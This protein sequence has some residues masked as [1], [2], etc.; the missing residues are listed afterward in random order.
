MKRSVVVYTLLH[1]S[2]IVFCALINVVAV[3]SGSRCCVK[4]VV[5]GMHLA[6]GKIAPKFGKWCRDG[7]VCKIKICFHTQLSLHL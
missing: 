4:Q 6:E 5:L 3:T 1:T 7:T 2:T